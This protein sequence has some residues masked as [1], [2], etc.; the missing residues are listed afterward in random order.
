MLRAALP[1]KAAEVPRP[2]DPS[3]MDDLAAKSVEC[4][5][6]SGTIASYKD[7]LRHAIVQPML[8]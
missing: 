5:W 1:V 6:E 3:R 8:F 7:G 4:S 2:D